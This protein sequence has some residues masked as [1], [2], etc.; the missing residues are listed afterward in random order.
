[1]GEAEKEAKCQQRRVGFEESGDESIVGLVGV[2]RGGR[3]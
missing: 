1:M 2:K 3:Q